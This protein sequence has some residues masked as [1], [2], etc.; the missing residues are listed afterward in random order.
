[1]IMTEPLDVDAILRDGAIDDGL[2]ILPELWADLEA[3]RTAHAQMLAEYLNDALARVAVG[4]R[5]EVISNF[6][7][8]IAANGNGRDQQIRDII[9]L[10]VD[11]VTTD[12]GGD[13]RE[14]LIADAIRDAANTDD[15]R[16][17]DEL[18]ERAVKHLARLR[19]PL[20]IER[21]KKELSAI[22]VSA[23]TF[24]QLFRAALANTA[25]DDDP[26]RILIARAAESD[27]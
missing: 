1:M 25:S 24:Q 5:P 22:G 9:G 20:A 7:L 16:K 17:R 4:A 10:P 21:W 26:I 11:P 2:T 8:W 23:G 12:E 13:I 3:D 27:Q 15:S 6:N 19:R 14:K 18:I